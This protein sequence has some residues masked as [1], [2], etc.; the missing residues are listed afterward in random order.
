MK[1]RRLGFIVV[2]T[3]PNGTSVI[4]IG[5]GVV[6]RSAPMDRTLAE[7]QARELQAARHDPFYRIAEVVEEPE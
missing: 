1:R 7:M 5:G 4:L 2:H 3:P 6:V